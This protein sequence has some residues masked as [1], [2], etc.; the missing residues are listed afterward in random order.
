MLRACPGPLP[1]LAGWEPVFESNAVWRLYQR[2]GQWA[3]QLSSPV[4]GPY[5]VA[6][7]SSGFLTGQIH[8]TAAEAAASQGRFAL[9]YPL[10][11]ILMIHL[12]ARGRGLL[13]HACAVRDGEDG[14][15]FAG[16]SGA[17]KSTMAR[18][19]QEHTGATLLSDDRV[20]LRE[21]DDDFWIYGTPWHGD[22]GAA[23][24]ERAPLRRIFILSHGRETR[25]VPLSQAQAS[26]AL[27]VRSF[28]TYW[29]P[30]GMEFSVRLLSR[31][32]QA[33]PVYTLEFTPDRD[34]IGYVRGF[35]E[36]RT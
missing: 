32:S 24:P 6:V 12:L 27:L 34:V 10:A 3:V 36:P 33:T 13:V 1:D 22:A 26:A 4:P 28:P 9:E 30:P 23:S 8:S 2:D 31:L 17:G 20:I 16:T 25:A 14:V 19:W 15:L 21:H 11:E 35:G 29:D 7:F 18:L 5:R